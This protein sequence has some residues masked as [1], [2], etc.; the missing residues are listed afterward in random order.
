[1]KNKK[2]TISTYKFLL[3]INKNWQVTPKWLDKMD[4][5]TE[6]IN[7]LYF[8][9]QYSIRGFNITF[10]RRYLEKKTKNKEFS[11]LKRKLI[12]YY[13]LLR[14][15]KYYCSMKQKGNMVNIIKKN[16]SFFYFR[17]IRLKRLLRKIINQRNIINYKRR[18]KMHYFRTIPKIFPYQNLRKILIVN[19]IFLTLINVYFIICLSKYLK[20]RKGGK[21]KKMKVFK[22]SQ[23]RFNRA[24]VPLTK[25][26]SEKNQEKIKFPKKDNRLNRNTIKRIQKKKNGK[27]GYN[28]QN[29]L[30]KSITYSK[31]MKDSNNRINKSKK[32]ITVSH[33]S[34]K[35]KNFYKTFFKRRMRKK[36]TCKLFLLR[37]KRG[38]VLRIRR[39]QKLFRRYL[40]QLT[41]MF[42]LRQYIEKNLILLYQRQNFMV[43]ILSQIIYYENPLFSKYRNLINAIKY[44]K[45]KQILNS[46]L[47]YLLLNLS[48]VYYHISASLISQ[49]IHYMFIRFRNHLFVIRQIKSWLEKLF[50]LST[51][52]KGLQILINGKLGQIGRNQ[53]TNSRIIRVGTNISIQRV[54]Q[55]LDYSFTEV[56][57]YTGS[58]GIH[59]WILQH[60]TINKNSMIKLKLV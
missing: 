52:C 38:I 19:T 29:Q 6:E 41:Q 58:Y 21:K 33:R 5:Q 10:K 31:N 43:L 28:N 34:K 40:F 23:N 42:Y 48:L 1:M 12:N 18:K 27:I 25:S 46:E 24:L 49:M 55:R 26:T 20:K 30:K 9:N 45:S 11:F 22:K 60:S 16:F 4:N 3:G 37:R 47:S 13:Y 39:Q 15:L 50:I 54:I 2:K 8:F 56:D 35:K 32:V 17:M 7:L 36:Q 14:C 51:D 53:R 59:V 44:R 57:T